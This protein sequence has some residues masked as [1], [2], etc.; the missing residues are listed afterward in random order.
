MRETQDGFVIAEEDLR[1]RGSGDLLGT[2][3]SGLPNFQLVDFS[4]HKDL[5]SI[6]KDDTKLVLNS[7]PDLKTRRGQNLRMLLYI[8]E[9]D[10]GVN[11]LKKS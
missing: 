6:A 2:R 7:D 3:Q 10:L 9:K 1:I 11:L 8:F 5:L 4:E